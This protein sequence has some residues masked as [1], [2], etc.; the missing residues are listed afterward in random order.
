MSLKG[1]LLLYQCIECDVRRKV[2]FLIPI[3]EWECR[4]GAEELTWLLGVNLTILVTSTLAI[5]ELETI[6]WMDTYLNSQCRCCLLQRSN[7]TKTRVCAAVLCDTL[8]AMRMNSSEPFRSSFHQSHCAPLN[9]S[10]LRPIP[11]Y[12]LLSSDLNRSRLQSELPFRAWCIFLY[13]AVGF[14][15][16]KFRI[17]SWATQIPMPMQVTPM[18]MPAMTKLWSRWLFASYAIGCGRTFHAFSI[19]YRLDSCRSQGIHAASILHESLL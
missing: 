2:W 18:S 14:L 9:E 4:K 1:D 10:F 19:F 17:P 5:L 6:Y 12:C 7:D 16:S 13:T 8:F 3:V 11:P 15:L